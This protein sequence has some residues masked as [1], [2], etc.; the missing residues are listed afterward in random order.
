MAKF[1][2]MGPESRYQR[3]DSTLIGMSRRKLPE[4]FLN[5]LM[6][7]VK[8]GSFTATAQEISWERVDDVSSS[9]L[10]VPALPF[11]MVFGRIGEP[12]G[13]TSVFKSPDTIQ[14]VMRVILGEQRKEL[15][16]MEAHGMHHSALREKA[17]YIK[18]IKMR[19]LGIND[20]RNGE[21]I[22]IS[23][24]SGF[25]GPPLAVFIPEQYGTVARAAGI[26]TFEMAE[27]SLYYSSMTL[28]E[29]VFYPAPDHER[30][31]MMG[32]EA[33][34]SFEPLA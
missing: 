8:T 33:V 24:K 14:V 19:C 6:M 1:S 12:S 20:S 9:I 32:R 23:E 25:V 27:G 4:P 15:E 16:A 30:S 7:H 3:T 17:T 2:S 28:G 31:F 5:G 29:G 34:V 18:N 10:Q 11:S 13:G 22:E 26:V 21:G